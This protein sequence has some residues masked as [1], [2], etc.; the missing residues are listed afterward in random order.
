MKRRVYSNALRSSA[1]RTSVV[2]TLSLLPIG[3]PLAQNE[4]A[5]VL[6][7]LKAC[8]AIERNN[9]RLACYDGVLGRPASPPE[10]AAS[11]AETQA[12]RATAPAGPAPAAVA[13]TAA[14]SA[15]AAPPQATASV[16]P[17]VAA[18][19]PPPPPQT[20][21][22]PR[23][24]VVAELRLRSPTNAVFVTADGQVWEQTDSNRGRYP[25][26][27]FEATLEKGALNSTFLISPAG[28]PR[29]RVRLRQ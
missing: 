12:P 24:I 13:G 16:A 26:T 7:D 18:A 4:D 11:S 21:S 14:A 5:D 1:A 23:T 3:A 25:E 15:A 2:L 10:P 9:A 22:A 29:I 27:P 17:E 6:A 19:A 20:D 28:G 8:A